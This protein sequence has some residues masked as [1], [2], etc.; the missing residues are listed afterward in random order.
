M[1]VEKRS[2]SDHAP[3]VLKPQARSRDTTAPDHAP[4]LG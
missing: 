2:T 1:R 4:R 3:T